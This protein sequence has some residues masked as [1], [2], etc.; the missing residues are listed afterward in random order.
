MRIKYD[1]NMVRTQMGGRPMTREELDSEI[2]TKNM[3]DNNPEFEAQNQL[4]K[5]QL[6]L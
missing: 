1:G 5:M 3:F 6:N 2:R 4:N